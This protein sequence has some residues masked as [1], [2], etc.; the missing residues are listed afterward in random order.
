MLFVLLQ[1]ATS[2]SLPNGSSNKSRCLNIL[3]VAEVLFVD[4]VYEVVTGA[5]NP[6]TIASSC[7]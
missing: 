6:N 2:L 5:L 3:L 4:V 7:W 1:D